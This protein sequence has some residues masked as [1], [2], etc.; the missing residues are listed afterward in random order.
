MISISRSIWHDIT[1]VY[2]TAAGTL[3]RKVRGPF[4]VIFETSSD[5]VFPR[6]DHR[7]HSLRQRL[8]FNALPLER[9]LG[10]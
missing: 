3:P 6:P 4:D 10:L 2:C 1:G 7:L 8:P 5:W 9:I